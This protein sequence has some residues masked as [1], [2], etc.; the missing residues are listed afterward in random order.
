MPTAL[1]S[2][3]TSP[4]SRGCETKEGHRG[5]SG[6]IIDYLYCLSRLKVF[7]EIHNRKPYSWLWI[8]SQPLENYRTLYTFG[9]FIDNV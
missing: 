2:P 3:K 5:I 1:V 7:K 8:V 4:K 9:Y 6:D